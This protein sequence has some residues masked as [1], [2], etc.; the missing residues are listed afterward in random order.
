MPK[1]AALEKLT[2]L[3]SRFGAFIAERHPLAL[4]DSLEAFEKATNG[5]EPQD[6]KAIEAV[7]P[8]LQRELK[9]RL[10]ARPIPPAV[11][12]LVPESLARENIVMPLSQQSA[13]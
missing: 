13:C 11:V 1:P 5:R 8:A 4:A 9:K 12:E 2:G 7:R 10:L 6:E 3:A